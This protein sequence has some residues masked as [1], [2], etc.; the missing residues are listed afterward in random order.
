V[1]FRQATASGTDMQI[2]DVRTPARQAALED[3][4]NHTATAQ[5]YSFEREEPKSLREVGQSMQPSGIA[6]IS[7]IKDRTRE[8]DSGEKGMPVK[9]DNGTFTGGG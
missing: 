5:P 9:R 1:I 8:M 2:Q 4:L 6:T 3:S 7:M